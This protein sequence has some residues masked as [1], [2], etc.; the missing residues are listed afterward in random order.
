MG[1]DG[2]GSANKVDCFCLFSQIKSNPHGF[3]TPIQLEE[4]ES[5]STAYRCRFSK[6]GTQVVSCHRD[7]SIRF[8]RVADGLPAGVGIAIMHNSYIFGLCVHPQRNL[9]A[10]ASHDASVS[11][12]DLDK[13]ECTWS[14]SQATKKTNKEFSS[15]V[16]HPDK[17]WLLAG[18]YTK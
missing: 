7:G 10:T 6:S 5:L 16:F 9:V 14:Y 13:E 17:D 15:V 12:W 18:S 2:V 8:T 11:I 4:D 3:I 1:W